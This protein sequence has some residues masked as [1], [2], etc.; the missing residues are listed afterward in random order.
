MIPV[1]AIAG[2]IVDILAA[3]VLQC[4]SSGVL[5]YILISLY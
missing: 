1:T 2:L 5:S 4:L 3:L